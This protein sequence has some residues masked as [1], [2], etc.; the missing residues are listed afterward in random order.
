MSSNSLWMGDIETWM[1][2]NYIKELFKNIANVVSVKIMK[3][4]GMPVGYCFVEFENSQIANYVLE[5]YNG[6]TVQG[7]TKVLK[8]SKAMHSSSQGKVITTTNDT[9]TL[10]SSETQIYVCDM[11]TNITEDELKQ[12]FCKH[13]LSVS[14]TKIVSDPKTRQSRGYGF[15]RFKDPVEANRALTEMN[16]KILN[17]KAIKVK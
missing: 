15:V 9:S 10:Q 6:K 3:K 1:D 12:F 8:L 17:S 16:G 7:T 2:E 14:S 11:D 4:N 13:Y 5:N